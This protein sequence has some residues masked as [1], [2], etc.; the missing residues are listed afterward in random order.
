[1]REVE[2]LVAKMV[3]RS[4]GKMKAIFNK[5]DFLTLKL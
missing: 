4:K 2:K 3:K 5:G 1:M